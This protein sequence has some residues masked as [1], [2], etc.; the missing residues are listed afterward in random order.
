MVGRFIRLLGHAAS[1]A[2]RRSSGERAFFRVI[3]GELELVSGHGA[4]AIADGSFVQEDATQPPAE[5]DDIFDEVELI[6]ALGREL[7]E[8]R[9]SERVELE[10]GFIPG[11][12]GIESPV[13]PCESVGSTG[14][15]PGC[16]RGIGIRAIP[17]VDFFL[18]F[19]D[20]RPG[21]KGFRSA[22]RSNVG[23]LLRSV[24]KQTQEFLR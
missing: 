19:H 8:E 16:G 9:L 17:F 13:E 20:Y 7:G 6:G 5:V 1:S 11:S 22:S 18:V 3:E 15:F 12:D 23:R 14:S 24:N 4:I 2:I 21:F 10:R